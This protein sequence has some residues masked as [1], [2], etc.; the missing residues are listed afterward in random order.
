MGMA[1]GT[2]DAYLQMP[3]GRRDEEFHN[4]I[5]DLL[6][7]WTSRVP[8]PEVVSAKIVSPTHG[9]LTLSMRDFLR[10]GYQNRLW[11]PDDAE[12]QG[13]LAGVRELLGVDELARDEHGFVLTRRGVPRDEWV[14]GLPPGNLATTV[15]G[16]FAAGDEAPAR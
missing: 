9:A 8:R 1:K 6:S 7:D 2:Y 13:H 16:I 10:S 14:D 12:S 4:A 15:P 5:P 3:R 11:H